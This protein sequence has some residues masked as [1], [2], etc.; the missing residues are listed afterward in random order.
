MPLNVIKTYKRQLILL[1]SSLG[2]AGSTFLLQ[3]LL[4]KYLGDQNFG[5]I[6]FANSISILLAAMASGGLSNLMLRRSSVEPDFGGENLKISFSLVVLASILCTFLCFSFLI[7]LGNELSISALLSLSV[8]PICLQILLTA[9]GQVNS[10]PRIIAFSQ[11][12]LPVIRIIVA[13]FFIYSTFSFN[14]FIKLFALASIICWLLYCVVFL[15]TGL[16]NSLTMP[17]KK[18]KDFIFG[19]VKYSLNSALN[20]AQFQISVIVMGVLNGPVYA[21]YLAICN[22]I[23]T[24]AYIAPNTIFNLH[25]LKIYHTLDKEQGGVVLAHSLVSFLTGLAAAALLYLISDTFIAF[26]FDEKEEINSI[27][28]ICLIAI[29]FRFYST[30]IGAALLSEELVGRKT[31][32]TTL[33]LMVQLGGFFLLGSIG[34]TGIGASIVLSEVFI[35]I[36]FTVLFMTRFK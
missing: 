13:V 33:G 26:L 27:L 31:V 24:A 20:V 1:S 11:V 29:P 2:A 9:H 18:Y 32:C 12:S 16:S 15:R 35:A 4:V 25:F 5:I 19:S 8:L 34:A 23:M 21:G 14:T 6:A 3:I 22:A 7:L 28:Q 17:V 36:S 10:D 30:G